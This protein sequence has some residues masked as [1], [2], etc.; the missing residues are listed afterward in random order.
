MTEA[1]DITRTV[2]MSPSAAERV[3]QLI[4]MEGKPGLMLR[5]FLLPTGLSFLREP[6]PSFTVLEIG[7]A[8]LLAAAVLAALGRQRA[9]AGGLAWHL[10]SLL[11]AALVPLNTPWAEHRAYLALP[12]LAVAV[13]ALL[14]PALKLHG[15]KGWAARAAVLTI[16]ALFAL[17]SFHRAGQWAGQTRLLADAARKGPESP[18]AWS[19]LAAD[20]QARRDCRRAL[21]FLAQALTLAPDFADAHNT[22]A[23]CLV[24]VGRPSEAVAAAARA[25]ELDQENPYYWRTFALALD[26]AGETGEARRVLQSLLDNLPP[27]HPLRPVVEQDWR[28]ID[29][30]N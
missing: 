10:F 21:P 17:G 23:V 1:Q 28:R 30:A 26:A 16:I 7:L 22:R 20:A 13:A 25:V 9:L 12:G 6:S 18:V 29:P 14:E 24:E 15:R 5:L 2:S 27:Q 11:P 8:A 3:G 19:F 4:E